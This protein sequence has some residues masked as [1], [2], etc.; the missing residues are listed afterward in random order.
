[1]LG[2]GGMGE[3]Y[4]AVDSKLNREV[5]IKVIPESFRAGPRL[6]GFSNRECDRRL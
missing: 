4:R 6:V 3:V 1:M 2:A 5:A